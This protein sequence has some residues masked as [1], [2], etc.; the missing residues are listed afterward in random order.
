[1]LHLYAPL[2]HFPIFFDSLS[3]LIVSV[4]KKTPQRHFKLFKLLVLTEV[5]DK[6]LTSTIKTLEDLKKACQVAK[7]RLTQYTGF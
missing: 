2:S 6:D 7:M 5:T 3:A 1:M 4:K